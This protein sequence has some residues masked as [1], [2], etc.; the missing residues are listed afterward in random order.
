MKV[1]GKVHVGVVC[2]EMVLTLMDG[3][4]WPVTKMTQKTKMDIKPRVFHELKSTRIREAS[5]ALEKDD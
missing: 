5:R 1:K 3:S 4:S 2:I